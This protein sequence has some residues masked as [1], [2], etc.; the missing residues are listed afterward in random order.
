M[1]HPIEDRLRD[2]YQAKAAQLTEQR[3]DQLTAAREQGLDGLLAGDSS[4][5]QTAEL[6]VPDFEPAPARTPQHWIAPA[7]AA[8]AVAALAIGVTAVSG[9][10]AEPR[11][12]PNPPASH[13]STP[14]PSTS[15]PAPSPSATPT[16][17][18]VVIGPPYLPAGQTGSR[19]QVPWSVVGTGWRLLLPIDAANAPYG[20]ITLYLYDPAGGRY[21]ISDR[22]PTAS[23]LLAWSPDGN[24][25][26]TRTGSG[27]EYRYR[28]VDL[29]TGT[30]SAGFSVPLS[31][32]VS[33]SQPRGLAIMVQQTDQREEELVRYGRDG[34]V[35]HR[36]ATTVPGVGG[37]RTWALYLPDGTEFVGGI[38]EG[39]AALFGNDGHLVRSYSMP[40]GYDYCAPV[41]WWSPG[42]FL[43]VCDRAGQLGPSDSLYLQRVIGG[44]PTLLTDKPGAFQMGHRNGWPL[45]NGDVLLENATGCGNGGYQVLGSD[46]VVR[47]LKL[48][49]GIT[50]PGVIINV[51]GD[52]ATFLQTTDFGCDPRQGP[53]RLIDYNLVTKQT[54]ALIEGDGVLMNWPGDAN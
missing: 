21:L 53:R 44:A 42:T 5:E 10:R 7:L 48:P 36:Y 16:H 32:F 11:P 50:A 14:P 51:D 29:H 22:L 17:T 19:S 8:A 4:S 47:S 37:F 12:R 46:G 43:E 33:Y 39:P 41:K 1:S 23:M 20:G 15:A 26:L 31:N 9:M 27:D 35:E 40:A 38:I 30:V 13:V 3:L 6:P 52:W 2:A 28:E 24:R 18:Q 49:A 25:A 54:R 34:T 45:S